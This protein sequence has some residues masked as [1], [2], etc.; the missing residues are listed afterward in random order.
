MIQRFVVACVVV[1]LASPLMAAIGAPVRTA[2]GLVSG[3]T[4]EDP[5]VSVFEGM[6]FAA[7]PTGDLRWRAPKPAASW[8]G[9]R[10]ADR[11]PAGCIQNVA[12]SRNPWT[13]EYMHQGEDGHEIGQ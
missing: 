5:A 12:R 11:M 3:V 1:G 2:S 8:D 13:E 9:V 4:G 7:P 6:P 10:K